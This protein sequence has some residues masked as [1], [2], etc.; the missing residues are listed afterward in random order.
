VPAYTSLG[1]MPTDPRL[2]PAYTAALRAYCDDL[3]RVA[4]TA[5]QD[6]GV[7]V[8]L[9]NLTRHLKAQQDIAREIRHRQ[10]RLTVPVPES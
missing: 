10:R 4:A 7:R 6:P 9:Y 1:L 2:V 5:P 3:D 8:K